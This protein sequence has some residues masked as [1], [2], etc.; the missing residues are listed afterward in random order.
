MLQRGKVHTLMVSIRRIRK[1]S[2]NIR[3]TVYKSDRGTCMLERERERER[4][5]E[6]TMDPSKLT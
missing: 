2:P 5:R 6:I 3:F 1:L 4:E